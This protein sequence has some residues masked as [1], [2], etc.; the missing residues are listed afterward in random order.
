MLQELQ[1]TREKFELGLGEARFYH[2]LAQQAQN[3]TA[4]G[5][6]AGLGWGRQAQSVCA[7]LAQQARLPAAW[8]ALL[9]LGSERSCC[10]LA[11]A[12]QRMLLRCR[13]PAH[14]HGCA[15]LSTAPLHC[16]PAAV[17]QHFVEMESGLRAMEQHL[18][19]D[20]PLVAAALRCAAGDGCFASF[21][22]AQVQAMEQHVGG[23]SAQ[24][25][26]V[27]LAVAPGTVLAS[28]L[29]LGQPAG[30]GCFLLTCPE[31]SDAVPM[32]RCGAG[33]TAG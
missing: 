12:V 32:P 28:V 19:G 29:R 16:V 5:E 21:L 6:P 24:G 20:S 27:G 26:A 31:L 1:E 18:G 25:G 7:G 4:D 8:H 14:A 17:G 10:E 9:L 15:F 33:S 30:C 2:A 22:G 11:L 3:L 23:G 13:P